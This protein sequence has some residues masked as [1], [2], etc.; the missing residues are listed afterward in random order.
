MKICM[1]DD[2][3]AYLINKLKGSK[4]YLEIGCGGST[5][6][7]PKYVKRIVTI[8]NSLEWID[9]VKQSVDPSTDI[10][11]I[12]V[13]MP[14]RP[15]NYG[16][17]TENC[18]DVQ[19]RDYSRVIDTIDCSDVD[20]VLIDGRFRVAVALHLSPKITE[21]VVVLFDDYIPRPQY[22]IV[23]K[24]YDIVEIVDNSL[25]SLRKRKDVTVDQE[26]LSRYELIAD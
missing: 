13:E 25:V 18:T 26:E 12:Y 23:E 1:S 17:P 4:S 19:K 20:L 3:S 2:R 24:Y 11:Y 10:T 14:I 5:V 6:E 15:K 22:K 8:D 16:R 7:A 9:L 21:D